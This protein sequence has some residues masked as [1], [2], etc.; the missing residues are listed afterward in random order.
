LRPLE[1]VLAGPSTIY[2]PM[3]DPKKLTLSK[4]RLATETAK[5][6]TAGGFRECPNV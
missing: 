6:E 2:P 4:M 1:R 3:T 5:L